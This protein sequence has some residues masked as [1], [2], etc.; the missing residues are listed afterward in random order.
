MAL[1]HKRIVDQLRQLVGICSVSC[2]DSRLDRGNRPVIE[3]LASWLTD[4][5]F[6]AEIQPVTED[7]RKASHNQARCFAGQCDSDIER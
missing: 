1:P 4:M 6:E 7:G 3:L 2:T 5:G